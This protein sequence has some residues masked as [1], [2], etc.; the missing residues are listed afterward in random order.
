MTEEGRQ[1]NGPFSRKNS[2]YYRGGR[3]VLSDGSCGSIG[4]GI[5]TAYAKREQ[6]LVITGRNV[7]KAGRSKRRIGETV[8]IKVL[9]GSG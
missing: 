5:A 7:K 2:N 8:R 9:T 6:N 3:A 4:Y 1:N